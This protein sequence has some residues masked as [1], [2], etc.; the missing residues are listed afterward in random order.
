MANKSLIKVAVTA[1]VA[2]LIGGGVAYGGINYFQ[3]NNIATSS[4]SVPT[5]SNKS[6]STSTTNVKVNVRGDQGV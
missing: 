2:G 3:N 6:G 1:L 4:T 5:G